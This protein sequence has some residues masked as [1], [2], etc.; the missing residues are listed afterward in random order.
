MVQGHHWKLDGVQGAA[1]HEPK[2]L[3]SMMKSLDMIMNGQV[4]AI[5]HFIV[6]KCESKAGLKPL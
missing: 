3:E 4:S 2:G 5:I 1:S 6:H